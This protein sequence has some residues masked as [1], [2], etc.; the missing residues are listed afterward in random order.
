MKPIQGVA[1][2][3]MVASMFAMAGCGPDAA[4][5]GTSKQ[6]VVKCAGINTCAGTAQCAGTMADGGM[7]SC[8]GQNSC[9]GQGWIEVPAQE[10]SDKGGSVVQ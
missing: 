3:S 10:C 9:A 6:A 2:A 1:I 4:S 8:A 7:H 5:V